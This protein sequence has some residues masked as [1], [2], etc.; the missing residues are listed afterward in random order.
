MLDFFSEQLVLCLFPLGA[1]FGE[2]SCWDRGVLWEMKMW[3][4]PWRHKFILLSVWF[5]LFAKILHGVTLNP[6]DQEDFVYRNLLLTHLEQLGVRLWRR[7][8]YSNNYNY[9]SRHSSQTFPHSFCSIL[10]NVEGGKNRVKNFP[11]SWRSTR[12]KKRR[13]KDGRSNIGN[14]AAPGTLEY[15]RPSLKLGLEHPGTVGGGPGGFLCPFHPRQFWF[16]E[17]LHKL[18]GNWRLFSFSQEFAI[19][20][21][22]LPK[23]NSAFG[24]ALSDVH[25]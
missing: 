16:Y 22:D 1:F 6:T 19:T 3:W 7:H 24:S 11:E 13:R 25:T 23:E 17:V 20:F 5:M 12:V 8:R 15:P 18:W 21:P 2:R 4:R 10:M 9:F 14:V